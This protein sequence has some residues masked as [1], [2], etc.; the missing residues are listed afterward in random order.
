MTLEPGPAPCTG[1]S[2]TGLDQGAV[3]WGW[4]WPGAW[5]RCLFLGQ[6]SLLQPA[7]AVAQVRVS[8]TFLLG[9]G[10]PVRA[11]TEGDLKWGRPEREGPREPPQAPG[12]QEDKPARA[13]ASRTGARPGQKLL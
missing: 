12:Y 10:H 8:F 11:L 2:P 4:R 9:Y 3:V 1:P 13:A 7:E 5:P 6:G